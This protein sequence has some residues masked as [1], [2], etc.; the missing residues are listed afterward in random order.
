MSH[1]LLLARAKELI[2][3]GDTVIEN[4]ED[5]RSWCMSMH[6][7]MELLVDAMGDTR[8]SQRELVLSVLLMKARCNLAPYNSHIVNEIDAT[9]KG[10]P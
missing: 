3:E 2:A 4:D 6:L 9:L 8:P 7:T 10:A 1:E 5:H